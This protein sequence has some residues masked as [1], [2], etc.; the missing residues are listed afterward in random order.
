MCFISLTVP[1]LHFNCHARMH[2]LALLCETMS[3]C[4]SVTH[5]HTHP[6][7]HTHTQTF[8]LIPAML[9][10]TTNSLTFITLT[11]FSFPSHSYKHIYSVRSNMTSIKRSRCQQHMKSPSSPGDERG[12][13]D[14]CV[15]LIPPPPLLVPPLTLS[16]S[17]L[18]TSPSIISTGLSSYSRAFCP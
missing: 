7:T 17:S 11:Q 1:M 9:T 16:Y 5:S 4:R 6:H 15:H 14:S 3:L 10:P 2:K 8:L 12:R 18:A 13:R